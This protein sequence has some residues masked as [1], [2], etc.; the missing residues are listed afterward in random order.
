MNYV[1]LLAAYDKLEEDRN[2]LEGRIAALEKQVSELNSRTSGQMII[3]PGLPP[4]PGMPDMRL[5]DGWPDWKKNYKL[6]ENS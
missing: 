1:E 3:G 4:E 6:T 5:L 2:N